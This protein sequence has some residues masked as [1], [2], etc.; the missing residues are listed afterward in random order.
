[1]AKF[2]WNQEW[3]KLLFASP[4]TCKIRYHFLSFASNC[5]SAPGPKAALKFRGFRQAEVAPQ[6]LAAIGIAD[7]DTPERIPSSFCP[8]ELLLPLQRQSMG[9]KGLH[10]HT[11]Q[12]KPHCNSFCVRVVR[13]TISQDVQ[14]R[15]PVQ[16]AFPKFLSRING[17]F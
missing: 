11:E 6:L 17:N 10:F 8:L 2:N 15:F 5:I 14:T 16:L 13:T 1:M 12:S 9:C 4:L 7:R 3:A